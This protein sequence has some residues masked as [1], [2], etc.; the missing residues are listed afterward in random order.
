[1]VVV[2]VSVVVP[3]SVGAAVVVASDSVVVGI[4]LP[5]GSAVDSSVGSAVG[6]AVAVSSGV[7]VLLVPKPGGRV[8]PFS[9]AQVSGSRPWMGSC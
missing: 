5:V 3:S 9:A 6:S 8:T 1:V 4:A 7:A 2:A